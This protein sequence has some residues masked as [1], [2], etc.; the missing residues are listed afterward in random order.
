M[1]TGTPFHPDWVPGTAN[2]ISRTKCKD[3]KR[4]LF[5]AGGIWVKAG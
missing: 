4:Q 2:L 3:E 1:P 5:S